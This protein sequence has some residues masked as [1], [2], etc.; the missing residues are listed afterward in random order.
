MTNIN[1]LNAELNPIRHLLALVSARHIVH[2]SR[3]RVNLLH[4]STAGC[5]P[6]GVI[7]ITGIKAH[8]ADHYNRGDSVPKL[9]CWVCFRMIWR[10]PWSWHQGSETCRILKFVINCVLLSEFVGWCIN[11]NNMQG[12]YNVK[13]L[14]YKLAKLQELTSYSNFL[15]WKWTISQPEQFEAC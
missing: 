14:K 1:P 4:V 11:C 3:I 6:Q 9:E 7:Q 8:L 10:T 12:I 5:H 13:S 2:V 15:N